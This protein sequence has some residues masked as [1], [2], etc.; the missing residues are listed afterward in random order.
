MRTTILTLSTLALTHGAFAQLAPTTSAPL[1]AHL[2]EVNKEWRTMDPRPT[3]G[4]RL[5]R[6]GSEA[7][8]I[9][10]HLRLVRQALRASDPAGL[11]ANQLRARHES[12]DRLGDYAERGIFPMN[13]VL[14]VRNPVFID[15]NGTACAVGQ[16]MIESGDR[17]L[18][19]RVSHDLNLAYVHDMHRSDVLEWAVAH[20]FN[21]DELAWIQPSYA[22]WH[23][24]YGLGGGTDAQVIALLRLTDGDLLVAGNFTLAGGIACEHVA[25]WNGIDYEPLGP[26]VNAAARCAVEFDGK[27]WLGGSFNAGYQD[28]AIWDGTAWTYANAFNGKYVGVIDLKVIGGELHA[29][30]FASGFAGYTHQVVKWS[31]GTWVPVGTSFDSYVNAI[32]ERDGE[33]VCGGAFTHI[34]SGGG[35]TAAHVAQYIGG[36]WTQLGDGLDAPVYDLHLFNGALFAGGDARV[37]TTATFGLARLASGAVTWELQMPGSGAYLDVLGGGCSVRT[38]IDTN[39]Q[40]FLGGAFTYYGTMVSGAGVMEWLGAPD[41][42]TPWAL[43]DG[44]VAA[45]A[46]VDG[47]LVMGG[48]FAGN[49]GL[50]VPFIGYT[51][52]MASVEENDPAA[53]LILAPNPAPEQVLLTL[54]APPLGGTVRVIDADGREVVSAVPAAREVRLDVRTLAAGTYVVQLRWKDGVRSGA[55]VKP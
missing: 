45:L 19:E 21:E 39:G 37:D 33:L 54:P 25:L 24:W 43:T 49:A 7:E 18:A 28:L 10:M 34:G 51:D 11:N 5:V 8:R 47:T 22:P 41:L 15:P 36:A 46:T 20:G 30:G 52:L 17:A 1:T 42:F 16:L 3:D 29:A 53:P 26:G 55:F 35:P 31:A 40:L 50:S 23:P 38:L 44:A 27:L 6:F 13:H 9:A 2:L 12:L 4:E 48:A 14:P 32:E